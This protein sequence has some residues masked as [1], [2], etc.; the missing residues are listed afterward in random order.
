MLLI[1]QCMGIHQR[2]AEKYWMDW[3]WYIWSL[4]EDFQDDKI[5]QKTLSNLTMFFVFYEIH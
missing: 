2:S 4:L 5:K 1:L 3:E